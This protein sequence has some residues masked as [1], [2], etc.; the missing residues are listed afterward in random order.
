MVDPKKIHMRLADVRD[1]LAKEAH[2]EWEALGDGSNSLAKDAHDEW[3]A[4]GD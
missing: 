2:D 3:G 4:L 1:T